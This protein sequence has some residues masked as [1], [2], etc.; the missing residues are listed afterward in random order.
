MSRRFSRPSFSR[1]RLSDSKIEY[2]RFG[3]GL[4]LK[5]V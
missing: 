1:R 5:F 3:G 2:F 4:N